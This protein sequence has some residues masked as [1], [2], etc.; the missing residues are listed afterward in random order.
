MGFTVF[1]T[2]RVV[3]RAY[4]TLIGYRN[5]QQTHTI[6]CKGRVHW[7]THSGSHLALAGDIID[8][9]IIMIIIQN[10][11]GF[12]LP[13]FVSR[14]LVEDGPAV[15]APEADGSVA[16]SLLLLMRGGPGWSV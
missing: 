6:W 10:S 2:L 11:F 9:H 15:D 13:S 5:K 14:P 8:I 1:V 12:H 3:K 7:H 16:S 4:F